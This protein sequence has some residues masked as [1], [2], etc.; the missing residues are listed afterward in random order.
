MG[1]IIAYI[2]G[3]PGYRM[4]AEEQG[5]LVRAYA[6]RHGLHIDRIVV[7]RH[8]R[9]LLMLDHV[10]ARL[11]DHGGGTL[12]VTSL[13]RLAVT[14]PGLLRVLTRLRDAAVAVR[15][16]KTGEH[17]AESVRA[18]MLGLHALQEARKSMHGEAAAVG[19]ARA[20][21]RGVVLGRP[22]TPLHKVRTVKV[23]LAEG[24]GVRATARRAGVSPATVLRIAESLRA[25]RGATALLGD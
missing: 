14:L 11:A 12:L 23:A 22:R 16:A 6:A 24:H 15:V 4:S 18:L 13:C 21:A 3:A 10:I 20:R 2:R 9:R 25:A 8:G 19:R 7:E 5:A 1:Q 17:D